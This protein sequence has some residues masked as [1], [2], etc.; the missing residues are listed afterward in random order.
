MGCCQ[1]DQTIKNDFHS[2]IVAYEKREDVAH[3]F[4]DNFYMDSV[5]RYNVKY[6]PPAPKK[7]GIYIFKLNVASGGNNAH[8]NGG[9]GASGDVKNQTGHMEKVWSQ[10]WAKL[11]HM[12]DM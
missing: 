3:L 2:E 11:W 12:F 10:V 9:S 7:Q 1:S 8:V 6:K 5:E 4:E